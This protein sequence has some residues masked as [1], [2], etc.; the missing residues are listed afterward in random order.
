MILSYHGLML[1]QTCVE[2]AVIALR[3]DLLASKLPASMSL[4]INDLKGRYQVGASPLREALNRLV[5]E[6]LV[7]TAANRGFWVPEFSLIECTEI[8]DLRSQLEPVALK[9]TLQ[10]SSDEWEMQLVAGAHRLEKLYRSAQSGADFDQL[11]A[12]QHFRLIYLQLCSGCS[13]TTIA[14]VLANLY[15]RSERYMWS[16]WPSFFKPRGLFIVWQELY[17]AALAGNIDAACAALKE[18]L[19]ATLRQIQKIHNE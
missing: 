15:A 19:S 12:C 17:Q 8:F 5:T 10:Q 3:K 1:K 13:A 11:Q 2:Q 9:Q 6:G 7:A 18:F 4:K 16:I 14:Q